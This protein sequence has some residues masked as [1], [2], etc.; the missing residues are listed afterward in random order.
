MGTYFKVLKGKIAQK[1]S[2]KKNPRG[3]AIFVQI[4][5]NLITQ[6]LISGP[7]TQTQIDLKMIT[8]CLIYNFH[9]FHRYNCRILRENSKIY[10]QIYTYVDP[11]CLMF[12]ARRNHVTPQPRFG[13][14][15]ASRRPCDTAHFPSTTT[16]AVHFNQW[17]QGLDFLALTHRLGL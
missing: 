9:I 11:P 12:C 17:D 14:T 3:H 8:T 5:P 16:K 4:G 10:P 2:L 7:K 1:N 15:G 13:R 6:F